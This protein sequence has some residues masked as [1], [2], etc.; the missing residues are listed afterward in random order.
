MIGSAD[1]VSGSSL[2]LPIFSDSFGEAI[3]SSKSFVSEIK[4]LSVIS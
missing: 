4:S 3:S 1:N 2:E